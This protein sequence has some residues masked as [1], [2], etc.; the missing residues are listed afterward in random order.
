MDEALSNMPRHASVIYREKI[1]SQDCNSGG[2]HLREHGAV[3]RYSEEG[4]ER[5]PDAESAEPFKLSSP[6]YGGGSL[7]TA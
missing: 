4:V 3:L 6:V 5:S 7:A 2:V 1:I